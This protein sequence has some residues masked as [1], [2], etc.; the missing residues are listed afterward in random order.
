MHKFQDALMDRVASDKPSLRVI[1]TRT[2]Q[3]IIK[4]ADPLA[5]A[6]LVCNYQ[7]VRDVI[8]AEYHLSIPELSD[9]MTV[10]MIRFT[11]GNASIFLPIS[12]TS[13]NDRSTLPSPTVHIIYCTSTC[14]PFISVVQKAKTNRASAQYPEVYYESTTNCPTPSHP[15]GPCVY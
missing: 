7:F 5:E 1:R 14:T 6:V 11:T 3:R 13:A 9:L 10:M 12:S 15:P 4:G 2:F 8:V